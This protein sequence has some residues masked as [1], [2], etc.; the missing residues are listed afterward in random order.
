MLFLTHLD[1]D[2]RQS[3]LAQLRDLWTHTSTAIEGN[4]LTLGETAFVLA[5]GLTV[6][7]KPLKDHQ[8]VTGHARAIDLLYGLIESPEVST[9]DLFALHRA[10]RTEVVADILHPIGA[11]K[12]EPNGT[13]AVTEEGRQTFIDYANPED[14]PALMGDWLALLNGGGAPSEE[15]AALTAYANLH[16]AFVRI[17]PFCDGNGRMARLL[18]NLP[19]LQG[20]WPP[21]LIPSTRRFEYIRLLAHY[22]LQIGQA[23]PG[24]ALL[25]EHPAS[26]AFR[27]FCRDCWQASLE[28]VSAA[29]A[30]QAGRGGS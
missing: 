25:P 2:L 17:H 14:V 18:S 5:N 22:E 8:E 19:V 13:H 16:L 27:E 6:S 10:V 12:R 24:L 9:D 21:I 26:L 30:R 7:G 11:W 29:H 4:T 3:L 1:A 28:L 15:S 20:G 23:R